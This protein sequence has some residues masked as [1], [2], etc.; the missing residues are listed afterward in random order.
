M[1]S[2]LAL[3][4]LE[5]WSWCTFFFPSALMINDFILA[6]VQF[7]IKISWL[8]DFYAILQK[9]AV[10]KQKKTPTAVHFL[11]SAFTNWLSKDH[12]NDTFTV[13]LL[14]V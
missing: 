4:L 14:S 6:A 5:Y 7:D 13:L 11:F 9:S 3:L 2:G 12:M 8:V 1:M 10:N